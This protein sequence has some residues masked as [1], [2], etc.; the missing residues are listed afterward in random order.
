ME[1]F[2]SV[3]KAVLH[4]QKGKLQYKS[5]LYFK[6]EEGFLDGQISHTEIYDVWAWLMFLCL[7]LFTFRVSS[8]ILQPTARIRTIFVM[9]VLFSLSATDVKGSVDSWLEK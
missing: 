7:Y 5:L 9:T 4:N 6:E 8:E 3:E 1:S 2:V